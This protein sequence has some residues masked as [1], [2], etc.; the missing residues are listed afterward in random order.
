MGAS[1]GNVT[2]PPIGTVGT[3]YGFSVGQ[4]SSKG[5]AV[6]GK[7][8]KDMFLKLLVAQMKYQDP[9]KPTDASQFLAQTAQ[10]TLVE[11]LDALQDSQAEMVAT[12]HIQAATALV[13]TTVSWND[14]KELDAEGNAVVHTGVVEGV[15]ISNG[16]PTLLVGK[17]EIALN[18]VTK[19][20]KTPTATP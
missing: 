5:G 6:D 20:S 3:N 4:S 12:N 9:T 18:D 14:P 8:D 15:T 1:V 11:K 17:F 13:G 10:F 7:S 16:V 19:V 2:P